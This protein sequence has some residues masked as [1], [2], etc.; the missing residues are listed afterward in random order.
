VAGAPYRRNR[1][2]ITTSE[3]EARAYAELFIPMGRTNSC[4]GLPPIEDLGGA[5]YEVEP[6]GA[7]EPDRDP[8]ESGKSWEVTEAV[9]LRVVDPRV[10]PDFAAN[11]P[12]EHAA[13]A[14]LRW[15]SRV[16]DDSNSI[17]TRA[18]E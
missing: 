4:G 6:R 9:V 12:K 13:A 14:A 2:Y 11:M 3:V 8:H 10:M 18:A 5:V 1:V 16:G 15:L 7:L 17:E